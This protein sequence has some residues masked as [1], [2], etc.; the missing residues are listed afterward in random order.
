VFRT[1]TIPTLRSARADLDRLFSA[2]Q[3]GVTLA[4]VIAIR[5][6]LLQAFNNY[7]DVLLELSLAEADLAAAIG[8]PSLA[9]LPPRPPPPTETA[10]APRKVGP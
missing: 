4:R 3:P 7:L 9:L 2:G 6:R 5:T 8:D 1:Q 10:P